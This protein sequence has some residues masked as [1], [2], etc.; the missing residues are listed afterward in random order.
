VRR[1]GSLAAVA[2][3]FAYR[4]LPAGKAALGPLGRASAADSALRGRVRA[5][6]ERQSTASPFHA[7]AQSLLAN[8]AM[9]DGDWRAAER[10]LRE[11]ERVD[12]TTPRLRERLAV[13]QAALNGSR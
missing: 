5:E 2:D 7:T 4:L 3:S 8:V 12:P 1:I 9:I 6:L 13:V 11:A 10:A